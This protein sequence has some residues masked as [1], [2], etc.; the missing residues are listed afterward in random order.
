M[1]FIRTE[2]FGIRLIHELWYNPCSI[3][4]NIE[5]NLREKIKISVKSLEQ[6]SKI[7][8]KHLRAMPNKLLAAWLS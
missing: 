5:K 7:K 2:V 6:K 8:I 3:R 4:T 1:L